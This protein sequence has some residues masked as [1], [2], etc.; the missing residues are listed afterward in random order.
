MKRIVNKKRKK[1][2]LW[3]YL[4]DIP[5]AQLPV[6][7]LKLLSPKVSVPSLSFPY[8]L[9]LFMQASTDFL[10]PIHST[11]LYPYHHHGELVMCFAMS[12]NMQLVA[13][14]HSSKNRKK[15]LIGVANQKGSTHMNF[16]FFFEIILNFIFFHYSIHFSSSTGLF[17][18]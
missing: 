1:N 16:V 13:V 3:P 7:F 4:I 2:K 11:S 14:S 15:L 17:A 8:P 6:P 12:L 18:S 9:F 10:L 5:R